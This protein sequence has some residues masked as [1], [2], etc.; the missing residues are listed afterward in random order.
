MLEKHA[1]K[2]L[3]YLSLFQSKQTHNRFRSYL[4]WLIDDNYYL[5]SCI[6]LVFLS[7]KYQDLHLNVISVTSE[8]N[9][10]ISELRKTRSLD[11]G[12]TR[13]AAHL[14]H[15]SFR[16]TVLL[17]VVWDCKSTFSLSCSD[18]LKIFQNIFKINFWNLTMHV[19]PVRNA[20]YS[21]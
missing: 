8:L 14:F 13:Y 2:N 19:R 7:W 10:V 6:F 3:F 9:Y 20:S 1:D 18:L 4:L 5:T 15:G 16:S 17:F 21:R 11:M 12:T